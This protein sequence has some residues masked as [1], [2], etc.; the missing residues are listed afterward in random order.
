MEAISK[1]ADRL[2]TIAAERI[3]DEFSKIIMSENA[4]TGIIMLQKLGLLKHIVPELELGIGVEQ[5]HHHIYD[6]YEHN[7]RALDTTP[8]KHLA[9]RLAAL[10]HDIAKPH[11]KRGRGRDCTFYNHDHVGARITRKRL[12]ALRY[13]REIVEKATLLVDNHM[14][15]YNVDEVTEKSVRRLVKKVGRENIKDLMDLRIGD[16]LGS[17]TPKGK[18][19]KLRHLEF[20]VDKVSNDPISVKMLALN[21]GDLMHEL[22]IQPG[23]QIGAILDVLLAEV[24]DDPEK[25]TKEHLLGRAKELQSKNLQELRE[26]SK[27]KIEEKREEDIEG[28]KK[29]HWVK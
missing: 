4:M 17:G 16:R 1:H 6:V 29:K 5:N 27:E 20:M 26:L 18:T 13:P 23:P 7:L 9:V 24:I 8:S 11:T 3:R 2:K 22:K 14:F 10:F 15:Y 19:Y 21:G 25:N 12:Q 28:M